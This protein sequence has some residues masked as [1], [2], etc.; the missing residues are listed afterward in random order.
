VY[1]YLDSVVALSNLAD[2]EREL[3]EHLA[4]ASYAYLTIDLD[5]LSAANAPGVSAPAAY[6]LSLERVEYL[7]QVAKAS[8]K[9]IAADIA[10]C[11]PIYDRDG[12]T[13][14]VASRLAHGLVRT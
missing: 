13:A 4:A 8:G 11:N 1:F 10:E 5:V 3:R 2:L 14:K 7:V 6:G 9:L 12:I